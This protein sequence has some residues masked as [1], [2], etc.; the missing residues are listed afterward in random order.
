MTQPVIGKDC[1]GGISAGQV[2]EYPPVRAHPSGRFC[3]ALS[4]K[5]GK[6]GLGLSGGSVERRE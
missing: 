1:P 3:S 5:C 6:F 4:K 2:G